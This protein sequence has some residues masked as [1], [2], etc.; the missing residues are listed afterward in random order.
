[1]GESSCE[2]RRSRLL[3]NGIRRSK[4]QISFKWDEVTVGMSP[5]AATISSRDRACVFTLRAVAMSSCFSC[6]T[7]RLASE[8]KTSV[9]RLGCCVGP[10]R[11]QVL[12][13]GPVS[14]S[15]LSQPGGHGCRLQTTEMQ[16]LVSPCQACSLVFLAR[17]PRHE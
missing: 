3:F 8:S 5:L 7:Q 16:V 6:E 15:Y 13:D 11:L 9:I 1:M 10:T 14:R 2:P 12:V 17:S 4:F